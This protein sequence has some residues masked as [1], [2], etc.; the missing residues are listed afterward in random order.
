MKKKFLFFG[1]LIIILSFT[2]YGFIN[3]ENIKPASEE[4]ALVIN[5]E[6]LP[7]EQPKKDNKVFEGF[8]Y[9]IGPRFAA[10]KKSDIDNAT[11]IND[12]FD[13]EH[14]ERIEKLNAVSVIL[15][16]DD[17][18]SEIREIGKNEMLNK[19]QLTLL[20]SLDYSTNFIIRTDYLEKNDVSGMLEHAYSTPHLTIV[21]EKQAS[22]FMTK[23]T[24]KSYFKENCKDVLENVDPEKFLA[25][26]L[27]FTVAKDGTVK[28]VKLDRDSGYPEVDNRMIEL[29]NKLPGT[30]DPAENSQGEKV[31]QELVISFGLMGC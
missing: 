5:N 30:W 13:E 25:A 2:T 17:K 7:S 28:N 19:E 6:I 8:I 21:P 16:I 9:D 18:Q 11:S 10:I 1:V 12:F 24:L 26:K 14:I 29:I 22:H 23:E 20:H 3:W 27:Y 15:V 31:E 4:S